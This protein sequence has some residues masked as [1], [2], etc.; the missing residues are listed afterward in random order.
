MSAPKGMRFLRETTEVVAMSFKHEDE[1][2]GVP[3]GP[4]HFIEAGN[5]HATPVETVVYHDEFR[6]WRR[7]PKWFALSEARDLAAQYGVMLVES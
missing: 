5:A 3:L 6:G 1:T 4:V 7:A 2:N